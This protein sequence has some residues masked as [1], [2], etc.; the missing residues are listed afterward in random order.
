MPTLRRGMCRGGNALNSW[1]TD[2]VVF[3]AYADSP[4][5]EAVASLLRAEDVPA[6]VERGSPIPGLEQGAQVMVPKELLHRANFVREQNRVT[7]A[8]LDY[9]ATHSLGEDD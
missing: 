7:D 3:V 5:A 2:W 6:R 8:E 9:L 1:N 4:S